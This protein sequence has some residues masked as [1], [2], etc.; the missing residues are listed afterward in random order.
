[1]S[2]Q[3]VIFDLDDTLYNEID[4]VKSGFKAVSEY[5]GAIPGNPFSK[6]NIYK[7]LLVLL[8]ENGRGEVFDKILDTLYLD[9]NTYLQTLIYIYRNHIPSGIK[10]N[11]DMNDLLIQLSALK[12]GIITDGVYVT[13]R[14]K[15]DALLKDHNFS[16]VIHTDSLGLKFWKPSKTPFQVACNL[17]NVQ[18]TDVVYIGDNPK[19]DFKGARSIGMRTIYWNP[20]EL[21]YKY[22]DVFSK[23]DFQVK[24]CLKLKEVLIKMS[25]I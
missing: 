10:L 6:N 14:N 4:F 7:K 16:C 5:L 11:D 23:P 1:M 3:A 24:N 21:N 13:Q 8:E 22:T 17:M 20:N 12:L 19:K 9:R 25:N 2:L 15:T 18:P